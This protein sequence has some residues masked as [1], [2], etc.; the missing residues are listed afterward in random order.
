L[1]LSEEKTLEAGA[2]AS[3]AVL[4]EAGFD[5]AIVLAVKRDDATGTARRFRLGFGDPF[6]QAGLLASESQGRN[7]YVYP[8]YEKDRDNEV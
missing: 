6:G 4:Q 8:H 7:D 2:D 1:S 3:L 5:Y